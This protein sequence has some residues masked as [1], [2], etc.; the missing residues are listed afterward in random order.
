MNPRDSNERKIKETLRKEEMVHM[1]VEDEWRLLYL[2][3]IL[4]E[5]MTAHFQSN[6]EEEERLQSL[7][8][9]LTIN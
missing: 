2:Q 3:R 5:R 7:I 6:Q 4:G 9:S 8:N 1:S